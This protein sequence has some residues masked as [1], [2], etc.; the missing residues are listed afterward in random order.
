[1]ETEASPPRPGAVLKE[2]PR[3]QCREADDQPAYKSGK[4]KRLPRRIPYIVDAMGG[5]GE[6]A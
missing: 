2:K 4:S 6:R 3:A 1:M 5:G